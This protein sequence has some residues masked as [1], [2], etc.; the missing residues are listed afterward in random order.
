MPRTLEK[1][2]G[3]KLA[4]NATEKQARALANRKDKR[5]GLT[6]SLRDKIGAR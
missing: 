2:F 3:I 4:K 6:R 1:R 5:V